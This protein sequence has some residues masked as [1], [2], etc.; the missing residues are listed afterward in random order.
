M[1]PPDALAMASEKTEPDPPWTFIQVQVSP[2]V[3]VMFHASVNTSV[4]DGTTTMFWTDR[5]LLAT[6]PS[7]TGLGASIDALCPAPALMPYVRR[8]GW[9]S[10]S[11]ADALDQDR[12]A[13]F[14]IGG[15]S[16]LASWQ[17]LQLWEILTQVALVPEQADMH[18]WT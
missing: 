5:W 13:T 9:R 15:L 2:P 3:R 11:V 10:L 14:I 4:G 18:R 6:R 1:G 8:R 12:W 7:H 17:C 16:V